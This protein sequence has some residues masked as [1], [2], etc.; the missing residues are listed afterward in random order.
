[1]KLGNSLF[2]H[3]MIPVFHIISKFF[4]WYHRNEEIIHRNGHN[5]YKFIIIRIIIS[6]NSDWREV[7]GV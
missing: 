3:R 2:K 7:V 5:E 1:M 6:V 4:F